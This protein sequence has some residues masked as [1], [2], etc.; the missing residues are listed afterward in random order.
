MKTYTIL[1]IVIRTTLVMLLL[2]SGS[3][4]HSAFAQ[5]STPENPTVQLE[6]IERI[7]ANPSIRAKL[8]PEQWQKY[9]GQ[10]SGALASG[11][12]GLQQ[13]ALRMIIQY[14]NYMQFKRAAVFDAVRIYRNHRNDN[15]RR[16]AV[17]AVGEMHD[18]WAFDFLK[19]SVPFEKTS[20]VHH[21]ILSVLNAHG[22]LKPGTA[23]VIE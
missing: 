19:R 3:I 15:M 17:V 11:H 7:L 8:T 1:H 14:G 23:K 2:L 21:T 13:G 20:R 16:M 9:A 4:R 12:D 5:L 6:T 22:M 10:L 18:P